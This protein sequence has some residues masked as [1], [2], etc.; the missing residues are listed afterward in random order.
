MSIHKNNI[1]PKFKDGDP[2][3][4]RDGAALMN[5]SL[6]AWLLFKERVLRAVDNLPRK[7]P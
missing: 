1:P 7:K 2:H 3:N 4:L 5:M 6:M